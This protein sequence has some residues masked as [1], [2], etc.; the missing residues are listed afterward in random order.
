MDP[1]INIHSYIAGRAGLGWG[2]ERH[3]ENVY[4]AYRGYVVVLAL[5]DL[6]V[7][8]HFVRGLEGVAQLFIIKGSYVSWRFISPSVVE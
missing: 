4:A 5:G 8:R 2:G 1:E 3:R 7:R 6:V